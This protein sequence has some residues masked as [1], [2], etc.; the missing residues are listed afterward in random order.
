[1]DDLHTPFLAAKSWSCENLFRC[2]G[3]DFPKEGIQVEDSTRL[4]SHACPKWLSFGGQLYY[5]L[6]GK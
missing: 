2:N 3:Y 5:D 1:M 4:I 6:I